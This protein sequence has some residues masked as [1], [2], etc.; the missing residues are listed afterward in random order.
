MLFRS[1]DS[2]LW[3]GVLGEG[4]IGKSRLLLEWLKALPANWY[5]FFARKDPKGFSSFVPFTDTVVVLDYIL[6][7]EEPAALTIAV[8]LRQ[9]EHT[10][11]RLRLILVERRQAADEEDWLFKLSGRLPPEDQ[12][13][14]E[15]CRFLN[16]AA[17]PDTAELMRLEP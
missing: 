3:W 5:G 2:V 16:S 15:S 1:S 13:S 4:G 11:Y 10:P 9:F 7:E 12:L 8:L 17:S 6:G 14:F